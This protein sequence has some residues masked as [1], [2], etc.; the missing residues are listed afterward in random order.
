MK[1]WINGDKCLS[2]RDD[3]NFGLFNVSI[4]FCQ[5]CHVLI[6]NLQNIKRTLE[7]IDL[8]DV[9]GEEDQFEIIGYKDVIIKALNCLK[10]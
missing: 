6:Y 3:D 10:K 5:E 7:R 9:V 4:V 1:C 2:Q 8:I